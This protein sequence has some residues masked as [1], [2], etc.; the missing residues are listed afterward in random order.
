MLHV[1][2]RIDQRFSLEKIK[3]KVQ[4]L[5]GTVLERLVVAL[6]AGDGFQQHAHSTPSA[7]ASES[8]SHAGGISSSTMPST[9]LKTLKRGRVPSEAQNATT[10]SSGGEPRNAGGVPPP[11]TV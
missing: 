1:Q 3:I 2:E 5:D 11:S 10:V 8:L 6:R 7:S 4:R 9:G